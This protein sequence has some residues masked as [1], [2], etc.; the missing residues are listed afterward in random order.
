[1]AQAV[2]KVEL[3]PY[4]ELSQPLSGCRASVARRAAA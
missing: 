3:N 4:E 2:L 1:M